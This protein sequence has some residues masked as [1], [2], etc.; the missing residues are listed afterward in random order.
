MISQDIFISTPKPLSSLIQFSSQET[1][2]KAHKDR[3][4]CSHMCTAQK[5]RVS[6]QQSGFTRILLRLVMLVRFI[7]SMETALA[8]G[9]E[10]SQ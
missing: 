2:H 8:N 3:A 5:R 4:L 6:R 7:I 9:L 1:S 10:G